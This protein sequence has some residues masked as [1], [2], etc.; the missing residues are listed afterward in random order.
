MCAVVAAW[1]C[2][3]SS[4]H[5]PAVWLDQ[6][7]SML[8][9]GEGVG[10]SVVVTH[11]HAGWAS[12]SKTLAALSEISKWMGRAFWASP[13]PVYSRG[14]RWV[15]WLCLLLAVLS[16]AALGPAWRA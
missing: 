7:Q 9:V 10:L 15:V 16:R 13:P 1:T 4:Q 3:L 5:L 6:I 8:K 14:C 2:R 12:V 11:V